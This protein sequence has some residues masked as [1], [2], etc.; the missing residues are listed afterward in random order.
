[1]LVFAGNRN[2]RTIEVG[3]LARRKG[4]RCHRSDG[5]GDPAARFLF[6]H[7]L[8]SGIGGCPG[9]SANSDIPIFVGAG[10]RQL[11]SDFVE[12]LQQVEA[13][14]L[15]FLRLHFERARVGS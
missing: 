3:Q 4:Q 1:M 13:L 7:D 2:T 6:L 5:A 11:V 9:L 12:L 8:A 10:L 14:G 15:Q